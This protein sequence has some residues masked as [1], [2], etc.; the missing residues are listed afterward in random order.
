MKDKDSA[1]IFEK[2]EAV[3]TE[4][5]QSK[6]AVDV[7]KSTAVKTAVGIGAKRLAP[8][9]IGGLKAAPAVLPLAVGEI[10]AEQMRRYHYD[11]AVRK[12]QI[13]QADAEAELKGSKKPKGR[14]Q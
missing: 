12:G 8:K 1:F 7:V 13:S 9:L 11:Q 5:L 3:Y 4:D 14:K 2:Y 6:H 10:G